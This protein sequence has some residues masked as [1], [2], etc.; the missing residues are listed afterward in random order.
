MGDSFAFWL[1]SFLVR[2]GS[3]LRPGRTSHGRRGWPGQQLTRTPCRPGR[4]IALVPVSSVSPASQLAWF[5][6]HRSGAGSLPVSTGAQ[7]NR[8]RS[9]R[10]RLFKRALGGGP[11]GVTRMRAA[12]DAPLAFLAA[13]AKV[14]RRRGPPVS[15]RRAA[16][17]LSPCRPGPGRRHRRSQDRRS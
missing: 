14:A 1:S 7:Q 16:P 12:H 6:E 3:F 13:P 4:A 17:R 2:L 11:G 15:S 10:E 9:P 5:C 8:V